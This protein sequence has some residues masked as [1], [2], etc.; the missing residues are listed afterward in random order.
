MH[1][2]ALSKSDHNS[3]DT[4]WEE[5][6]INSREKICKLLVELAVKWIKEEITD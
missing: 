3:Y 5:L 2:F 6:N 1:E 4:I